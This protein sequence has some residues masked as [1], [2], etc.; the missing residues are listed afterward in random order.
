MHAACRH[1]KVGRQSNLNPIK[2]HLHRCAG[3]DNFL[4]RF[5]AGPHAGEAAHRKR[6]HAQIQNFLDIRREK[7]RG[8]AGFEDVVA[9]VRSSGTF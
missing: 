8:A 2:V 5:H 7:Y 4:N 6:M 1:G 9:L 3:L